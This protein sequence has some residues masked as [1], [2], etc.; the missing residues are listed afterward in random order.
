MLAGDAELPMLVEGA[1]LGCEARL[2]SGSRLN[3]LG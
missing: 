2:A 1:D 3:G